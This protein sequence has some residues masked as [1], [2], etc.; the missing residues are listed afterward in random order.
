[1]Y[2]LLAL[3][4][5]DLPA[6]GR[7]LS[8]G[9]G[10]GARHRPI[11]QLGRADR[12]TEDKIAGVDPRG[13][14]AA[15]RLPVVDAEGP[16]FR[17]EPLVGAAPWLLTEIWRAVSPGSKRAAPAATQRAAAGDDPRTA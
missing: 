3:P 1:M 6:P 17:T 14:S 8:R 4:G 7:K 16:R 11:A 2:P 5:P 9:P 12:L 13:W 15:P 10:T